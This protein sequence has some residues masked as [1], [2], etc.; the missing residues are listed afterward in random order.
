MD[1]IVQW[2]ANGIGQYMPAELAVFIISLL[3]LLECR[4]GLLAASLL[5]VPITHAIPICVIGNII[6]IPLILIFIKKIF[7]WMRKFKIFRPIVDKLEARA[8]NKSGQV[9]GAEFTGLL[10]F[11]GIPVPG[12]GAWMGSLIAALLEMDTKKA[13]IAELLGVALATTIMSIVSYGL[14]GSILN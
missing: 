3:P 7:H 6:P 2:F 1:V 13:V 8:M 5:K 11:V 4:G 10:L 12:T 9:S 14:L